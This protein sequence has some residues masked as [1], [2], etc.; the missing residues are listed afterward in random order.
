MARR[1]QG[2]KKVRPSKQP[3]PT[4][5]DNTLTVLRMTARKYILAKINEEP[6]ERIHTLRGQLRGLA[7]AHEMWYGSTPHHPKNDRIKELEMRI[8]REE[9]EKILDEE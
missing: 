8:V 7:I 9:R 5:M 2:E 6:A 1:V 4:V 3:P